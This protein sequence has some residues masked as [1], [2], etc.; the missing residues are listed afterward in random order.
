TI[1]VSLKLRRKK[2]LPDPQGAPEKT[3]TRGEFAATYGA[4]PADIDKV[5][6]V[7]AGLGLTKVGENQSARTL[8]FSGTVPNM[9]NAFRTK[10]LNYASPSGNYRGRMGPLQVPSDLQGIVEGVVELVN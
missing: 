10:L 6:Q 5:T 8:R 1:E 9:E 2:E 7:L 4:S 3:M